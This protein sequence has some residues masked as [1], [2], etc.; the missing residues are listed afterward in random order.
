[1][2]QRLDY[3]NRSADV[4]ALPSSRAEALLIGSNKFFSG[5]P[6]PHGHVASRRTKDGWCDSCSS[7]YY[8]K[9]PRVVYPH[10][11]DRLARQRMADPLTLLFQWARHRAKKRGIE[12]R[13]SRGDVVVPTHCPCCG[14]A[15]SFLA[16]GVAQPDTMT[17][18]RLDNLLGYIPG[19]VAVICWGCNARKGAAT[20][21]QLKQ[22]VAWI[23]Q[24][25]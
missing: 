1:M 5:V 19:N 20:L 10:T 9:R 21:E 25:I 18:D 16:R 3:A 2:A 6:C 11:K 24:R 7:Q 12:F 15:L 14:V 13:L 8:K 23:E 17:L 4:S 22:L